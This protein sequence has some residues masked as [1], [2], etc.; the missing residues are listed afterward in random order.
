M[1]LLCTFLSHQSRTI[2]IL[3]QIFSELIK[4]SLVLFQ[5][6][7][8]PLKLW[9]EGTIKSLLLRESHSQKAN[10]T[11]SKKYLV[12]TSYESNQTLS[13]W[14]QRCNKLPKVTINYIFNYRLIPAA[15][16]KLIHQH[17]RLS[18]RAA[19]S[20]L[21]KQIVLATVSL[22]ALLWNS[23]YYIVITTSSA[24]QFGPSL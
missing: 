16:Y 14:E 19:R 22:L 20:F 11:N 1:S 5:R 4:I 24:S 9:A 21:F 15:L 18:S 6:L 10:L 2:A 12:I 7:C 23:Y 8:V 3:C 17:E 13:K